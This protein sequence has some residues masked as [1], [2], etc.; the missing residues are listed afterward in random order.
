MA[1]TQIY[2]MGDSITQGVTGGYSIRQGG[3]GCWVELMAEKLG[4]RPDLGPLL[5]PGFRQT[6]LAGSNSGNEWTKTP[7]YVNE[8]NPGGFYVKP[9]TSD[10][11]DRSVCGRGYYSS[12]AA[13]TL[14]WTVSDY[15]RPIVSF[16]IYWIDYTGGGNWQYSLDDGSTWINMGQT[17]LRDNK[18]KKFHV[19][20]PITST[21]T[22]RPYNGASAVGCY[23]MG[24]EPYYIDPRSVKRGLIVHNLGVGA[25]RLSVNVLPT[26]SGDRLSILDDVR[27]GTGSPLPNK[28]DLVTCMFINDTAA[29]D[30]NTGL[31]VPIPTTTQ[32]NDYL[33]TIYN[34]VSPYADLILM[35]PYEC[36]TTFYNTATQANFR[37][38]LKSTAASNN[39]HYI[40]FYDEYDSIGFAGNANIISGGYTE[41][42]THPSQLGHIDMFERVSRYIE[43]KIYPV[44]GMLYEHKVGST[45]VGSTTL[46][47]GTLTYVEHGSAAI[48]I[49]ASPVY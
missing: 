13:D 31:T 4:K 42:K 2:C 20:S 32:W 39:I 1:I 17:L 30:I 25:Q 23:V 16:A 26:T 19:S 3:D 12:T 34:R 6:H 41:D 46:V 11:F 28:P 15:M 33:K 22:F 48:P 49:S 36:L 7:T 44:P 14:K 40:D 27:L 21:V 24:I 47:G 37:T 45:A 10:A 8:A 29:F 5:G 18:L 38:Q 43:S 9:T 35:N